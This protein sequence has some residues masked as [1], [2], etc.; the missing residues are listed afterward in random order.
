M[1]LL[2]YVLIGLLAVSSAT[3]PAGAEPPPGEQSGPQWTNSLGMKFVPVPGTSVLFSI[4]DTRVQDYE[5]F[6]VATGHRWRK[7]RFQ[8]QAP[9]HPAA[10]VSWKDA[11]AFC[12]WLTQKEQRAGTLNA[13]Q[14]Y[15]LPTD[16]EWSTAV[17]MG[18]E[19]G[20]T[21]QERAN[22]GVY[23]WGRQWPPPRGAGNY[24]PS[25]DVDDFPHTSPVGSFA[26]NAF[27]LYDMGGNV[28]QWCE[29]FFDDRNV[30]RV[31]RGASWQLSSRSAL[32]S[33]CRGQNH[34]ATSDVSIGF[35]CVLA[36]VGVQTRQP[37]PD[38]ASV[39]APAFPVPTPSSSAPSETNSSPAK[40]SSQQTGANPTSKML[41]L[42]HEA[43]NAID[44][45]LAHLDQAVPGDIRRNLTMLREDLLDEAKDKPVAGPE[46]YAIGRQLCDALIAALDERDATLVRFGYRAAQASAD[47]RVTSQALE[48]RRNYMMSWPQYAREQR[49]A[50]EI[51][52]QQMENLNLKKELPKVEW[53]NRTAVLRKTLETLYAK[54]RGAIR[55]GKN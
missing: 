3:I 13:T 26:A 14:K 6:I 16:L 48:A 30:T 50:T 22:K 54:Y 41:I 28:R 8:Q 19:A 33:S 25:Y 12:S 49:Q 4:W 55:H 15:R 17:G 45:A 52:R 11:K 53:S 40:L 18:E 42:S 35:R 31:L 27:G 1:R 38:P 7:P 20:A 44:W 34:P 32:K 43:A 39:T 47:I 37:L 9:T 21:P 2:K 10:D 51:F 24:N 23:P 36:A 46:A 5:A 29:D